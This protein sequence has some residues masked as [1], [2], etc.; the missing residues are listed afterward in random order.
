[1]GILDKVK[2]AAGDVAEATKK[3]ASQVQTKVHLNQLRNKADD[4]AKRLGYLIHKEKT[5][6]P[7]AG[8]EGDALVAEISDL[9]QQIAETSASTEAGSGGEE[10]AP[11]AEG[12]TPA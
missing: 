1:M 7:P 6:G 10:P 12:T 3:G 8:A 11:P 4:A 2:Q 9:E 5:G